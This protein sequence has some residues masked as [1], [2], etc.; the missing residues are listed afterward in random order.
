MENKDHLLFFG[1]LPGGNIHGISISNSINLSILS[2]KFVVHVI[3][4]NGAFKK[5]LLSYFRKIFLLTANSLSIIRKCIQ[6][7]YRYFYLVI[8][9]SFLGAVKTLIMM[10]I[11]RILR[12]R[13][14]VILHVHRGDFKDFIS[15]NTVHRLIALLILKLSEKVIFLSERFIIPDLKRYS[16]IVII[17]NTILGPPV[18]KN[19]SRKQNFVYISNYIRN[20][21][22]ID[23]IEVME[24]LSDKE[25][26]LET[27][28]Q[29]AENE[30]T[31]LMK[32]YQSAKLKINGPITSETEKFAILGSAKC[33]ILPSLNE[34]QPLIILEAMATGT[35]VIVTRVGDMEGL[36]GSDYPLLI[37]PGDKNALMTAILRVH[38]MKINDLILL[39]ENLSDRFQNLFSFGKH[40]NAML[41]VFSD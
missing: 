16:D 32:T 38:N 19:Y 28:G 31:L 3:E 29:F 35:P 23:L 10:L 18:D 6:F 41:S 34:G 17:P 25:I 15:R 21:G 4:E 1:E 30:T 9:L 33:L 24:T 14:E 37:D 12:F 22:I 27:Y 40:R 5:N 2:E 36:V 7:R 13:G 26:V 11:F 39:S 8:S 20:K